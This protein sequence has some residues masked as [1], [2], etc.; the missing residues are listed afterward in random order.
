[1]SA[2]FLSALGCVEETGSAVCLSPRRGSRPA[3]GSWYVTRF[4]NVDADPAWE[5]WS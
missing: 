1:M 2:D 3:N 4:C 5:V